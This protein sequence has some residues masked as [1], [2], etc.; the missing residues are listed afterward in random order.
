M[1]T[2]KYPGSETMVT[3]ASR[4]VDRSVQA[5]NHMMSTAGDSQTVLPQTLELNQAMAVIQSMLTAGQRDE[6]HRLLRQIIGKAPSYDK[7]WLQLLALD[8]SPAEE[9]ELLERFLHTHP[10]HRFARAFQ[11]RLHETRIVVLLG[12]ARQGTINHG[13][14]ARTMRL[15]DYLVM[16]GWVTSEQVEQALEEQRRLRGLGIEERLGTL[17]LLFGHVQPEQLAQAFAET[18]QAGFGEFGNY[19]VREGLLTAEQ[20][21]K[22]LARQAA[23]AA[24]LDRQYFKELDAYQRRPS[25]RWFG[26]PAEK[27]ERKPVP[28]LGEILVSMGVL[29]A[30]QVQQALQERERAFHNTFA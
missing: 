22:A 5:H 21:S 29:N 1:Q 30:D 9:V 25:G 2:T 17:L 24:D 28:K 14:V 6:A 7:A 16:K 15:G 19:L 18:Q 10:K 13:P 8:P 26:K 20:I 4:S 23:I 11:A 27:P 3:A 12:D